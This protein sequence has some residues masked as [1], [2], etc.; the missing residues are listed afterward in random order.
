MNLS[1]YPSKFCEVNFKTR[2]I[3]KLKQSSTSNNYYS[4]IALLFK[5]KDSLDINFYLE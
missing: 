3:G 2:D 5:L 4:K 1:P